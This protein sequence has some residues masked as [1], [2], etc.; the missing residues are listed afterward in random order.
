M[1]Q[2]FISVAI[3]HYLVS[4]CKL[5]I[6]AVGGPSDLMWAYTQ[7]IKQEGLHTGTVKIRPHKTGHLK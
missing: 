3:F 7:A 1:E 6:H 2:V 5:Q 4:W